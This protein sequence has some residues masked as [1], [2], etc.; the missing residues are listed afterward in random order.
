MYELHE[1]ISQQNTHKILWAC[2]MLEITYRAIQTT[3]AIPVKLIE[4]ATAHFSFLGTYTLDRICHGI[5]ASATS[6]TTVAIALPV[7]IQ[8]MVANG[9]H[10][11]FSLASTRCSQMSN[12][13]TI[14]KVVENA[15]R[16]STS[17]HMTT[18][19]RPVVH[20]RSMVAANAV[21]ARAIEMYQKVSE[22]KTS[23]QPCAALLW[24]LKPHAG[25]AAERLFPMSWNAHAVVTVMKR[26]FLS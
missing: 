6:M 26:H 2:I 4:H 14:V 17:S 7:W 3:A 1:Y 8:M 19:I 25:A 20:R 10:V 24:M 15:Q 12:Q 18:L 9:T 21:L 13:V 22:P 23:V 11:L 16:T 5:Q